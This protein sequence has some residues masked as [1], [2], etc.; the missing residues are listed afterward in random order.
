MTF[1]FHLI[2]VHSGCDRVI[3]LGL[4]QRCL[5]RCE[6]R[7]RGI[8]SRATLD[9]ESVIVHNMMLLKLCDQKLL[10]E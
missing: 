8:E 4:G 10:E 5:Q 3:R 6:C 2:K 1:L 9:W 7:C